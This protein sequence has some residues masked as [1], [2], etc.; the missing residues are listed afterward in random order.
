MARA[1]FGM[2]KQSVAALFGH[3]RRIFHTIAG[4]VAGGRVRYPETGV[5]K[6]VGRTCALICGERQLSDW[7]HAKPGDNTVLST[8]QTSG[9]R[10]E[11]RPAVRDHYLGREFWIMTM[12]QGPGAVSKRRWRAARLLLLA[13]TDFAAVGLWFKVLCDECRATVSTKIAIRKPKIRAA[14]TGIVAAPG[15]PEQRDLRKRRC[16]NQTRYQ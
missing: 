8:R 15:S 5:T 7:S 14:K 3:L 2:A 10:G 13:V 12:A 16:T 4:P 1:T 9:W 6:S 11:I